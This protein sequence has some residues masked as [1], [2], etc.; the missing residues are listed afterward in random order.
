[1]YTLNFRFDCSGN[2]LCDELMELQRRLETEPGFTNNFPVYD[3]TDVELDSPVDLDLGK[4]NDS[5][6]LL[7]RTLRSAAN[8]RLK[9]N[10]PPVVCPTYTNEYLRN[11]S[12]QVKDRSLTPWRWIR[13]R[14]KKRYVKNNNFFIILRKIRIVT[15]DRDWLKIF[16]TSNL[17]YL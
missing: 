1:M 11:S 2:P 17:S 9:K 6:T 5:Q 3:V 15:I 13:R 14:N 10:L 16:A 8:M 12:L 4:N 7:S